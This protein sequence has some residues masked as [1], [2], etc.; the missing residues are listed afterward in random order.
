MIS[1]YVDLNLGDFVEIHPSGRQI[2]NIDD[3]SKMLAE[4]MVEYKPWKSRK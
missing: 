2:E 3:L 4:S 1:G